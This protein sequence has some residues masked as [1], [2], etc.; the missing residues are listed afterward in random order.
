[1]V[2]LSDD[3]TVVAIRTKDSRDYDYVAGHVRVY[4][5][6][7]LSNAWKKKGKDIDGPNQ[8]ASQGQS[9]SLAS[10]GGSVAIGNP[11]GR[12]GKCR[13]KTICGSVTVYTFVEN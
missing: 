13:N 2:S 4:K 3:G 5:W 10:D 8:L 9:V 11:R 12:Y 1:M 7:E 6:N